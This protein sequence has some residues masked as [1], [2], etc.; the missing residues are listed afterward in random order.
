VLEVR[1]PKPEQVKPRK[2]TVSVGAGTEARGEVAGATDSPNEGT[3]PDATP[4]P[5]A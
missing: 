5:S 1:I 4:A 2:V 3:T